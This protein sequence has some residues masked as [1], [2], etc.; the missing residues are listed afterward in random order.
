KRSRQRQA[1]RMAAIRLAYVEERLDELVELGIAQRLAEL[2]KAQ[3]WRNQQEWTELRNVWRTLILDPKTPEE[4]RH[5][6]R[7]WLAKYPETL[8]FLVR[9]LTQMGLLEEKDLLLEEHWE[10]RARHKWRVQ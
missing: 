2:E 3:K 1:S 10:K 7:E 5:A 9:R 8:D 6:C 4:L